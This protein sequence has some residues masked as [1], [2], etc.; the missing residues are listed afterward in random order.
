MI[1]LI[2]GCRASS[3]TT[4]TST[5][6]TNHGSSR[7]PRKRLP[8]SIGRTSDVIGKTPGQMKIPA[9]STRASRTSHR[10]FRLSRGKTRPT[11]ERQVRRQGVCALP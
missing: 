5:K 9:P 10:R 2:W 7:G 6:T 8:N 4:M 1:P 11:I 3:A